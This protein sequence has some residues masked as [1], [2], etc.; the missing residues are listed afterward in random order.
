MAKYRKG[1]CVDLADITETGEEYWNNGWKINQVF[2]N[3]YSLKHPVH[4]GKT[5]GIDKGLRKSNKCGKIS[6]SK[7]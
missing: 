6:Y 4:K 5:W 1:Q 3:Y 7:K 2:D